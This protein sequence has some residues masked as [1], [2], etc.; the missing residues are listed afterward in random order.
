MGDAVAE[1]GG[2]IDA[3]YHCPHGVGCRCRKPEVGMFEDAAHDFGLRLGDTAVV[4]D[5]HIDMLA[6][7]R[8]GALRVLVGGREAAVERDAGEVDYAALDLADAACW[9][10]REA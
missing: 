10:L 9:L 7:Q 4:G 6:A 5:S 1:N 3:V 2:R 8:I